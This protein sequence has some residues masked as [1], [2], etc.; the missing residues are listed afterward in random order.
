M[1]GYTTPNDAQR[2]YLGPVDIEGRLCAHRVRGIEQVRTRYGDEARPMAVTDVWEL[3]PSTGEHTH[4]GELHA[5]GIV[6]V[7][8]FSELPPG[9][10]HV[11]RVERPGKAW[12]FRGHARDEQAGI[13]KAMAALVASE[14][15]TEPSPNGQRLEEF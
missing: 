14:A 3:D 11:A 15:P 4:L 5:F 9:S 6:L 13:D 12:I 7:E 2:D 1:S 8:R 10:W